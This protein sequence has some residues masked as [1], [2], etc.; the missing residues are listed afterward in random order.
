LLE[1]L[2]IKGQKIVFALRSHEPKYG[3]EYLIKAASIVT[4]KKN[5]MGLN[6]WRFVERN[7]NLANRIDKIIK[8]Y[9]MLKK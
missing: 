9:E 7:F 1:P 8:L 2:N 4:K 3:L 5:D 6:G